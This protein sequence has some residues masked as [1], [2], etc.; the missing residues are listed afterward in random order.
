MN[1]G[2]STQAVLVVEHDAPVPGLKP[3][4]LRQPGIRLIEARDDSEAMEI[5]RRD[6]PSLIVD[7]AG[8]A[9]DAGF[10]LCNRLKT[11]PATQ[12]IPVI[13]VVNPQEAERARN[14]GAD[15]VL[16]HPILLRQYFEAASQYLPL[17]RRRRSRHPVNL[18]VTFSHDGREVQAFTRNLSVYGAFVKT[19]RVVPEGSRLEVRFHLPGESRET[20]CGALVHR[21]EPLAVD[22]NRPNGFGV[23]FEGFRPEE[24]QRLGAFIEQWSKRSV[25]SR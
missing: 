4:F 13:L 15:A 16:R 11:N 24:E 3:G 12:A 9:G 5:I 23:E 2:R 6:R 25:F 1:W 20:R 7:D 8:P 21:S 19:D 10:A 18:R 14:A 17:P 22:A